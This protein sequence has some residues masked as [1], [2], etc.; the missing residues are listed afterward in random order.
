MSH[1]RKVLS[2]C[3]SAGILSGCLTAQLQ[4]SA[5]CQNEAPASKSPPAAASGDIQKLRDEIQLKAMEEAADKICLVA[6]DMYSEASKGG[7][8]AESLDRPQKQAAKL[9]PAGVSGSTDISWS[10][11]AKPSSDWLGVFVAELNNWFPLLN[12]EMSQILLPEDTQ[13]VVKAQWTQVQSDIAQG[14]D[15]YQRLQSL[16]LT[17]PPDGPAI[18]ERAR[19]LYY[20]MQAVRK[21][22][23][24]IYRTIEAT[25]TTQEGAPSTW[26]GVSNVTPSSDQAPGTSPV[27][28]NTQATTQLSGHAI[29]TSAGM[30]ELHAA[31]IK[32]SRTSR[33]L[34]GEL[35]RWNLLWGQPPADNANSGMLWGGGL[36]K[37]E[38]LSQFRDMPLTVF[39]SP[40]YVKFFSY[41]LPPRKKWLLVYT[42]QLGQLINMMV[43][44][45]AQ[46]EPPADAASG[47][48]A[49]WGEIKSLSSDIAARYI[50]LFNLVE[51]TTDDRLKKS[52]RA[53]QLIFGEPV[54]AIYQD[55]NKMADLLKGYN[56]KKDSNKAASKAS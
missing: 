17:S 51:G 56:S 27:Q 32:M 49:Q 3:L 40:N 9:L 23:T 7:T 28:P 41:R 50:N 48:A 31:T 21:S 37:E 46:T 16:V 25:D 15:N 5:Y 36:T 11:D 24:D 35:E 45:I 18:A 20:N 14:Q 33:D 4:L 44:V 38:V 29:K 34:M 55:V 42:R 30:Q 43:K 10:G 22:I 8:P 19:S 6:S 54:A 12:E 52:I 53:D 2:L 13:P 26:K 39:T 47:D 1:G